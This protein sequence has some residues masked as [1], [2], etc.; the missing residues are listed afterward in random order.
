MTLC[1]EA[2]TGGTTVE[3]AGWPADALRAAV[4]VGVGGRGEEEEEAFS[5]EAM[6]LET[7]RK[8]SRYAPRSI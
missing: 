7:R 6:T 1:T 4:V 5:L 2:L 8:R 3:D